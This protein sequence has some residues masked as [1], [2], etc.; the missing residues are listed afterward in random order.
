MATDTQNL[1][2]A[3]RELVAVGASVGAGCHPC[4]AHHLKAGAQAG[5]DGGQLLAAATSAEGVASEATVLVADHA[6][7]QLGVSTAATLTPLADAL[8]ALGAAL[9][10]NDAAAIDLQLRAALDFGASRSQLQQAIETAKTVQEHAGRIHIRKAERLLDSITTT[11]TATETTSD[12]CGCGSADKTEPQQ[13]AAQASDADDDPDAGVGFK[14]PMA[15][16]LGTAQ[17]AEGFAPVTMIGH[18][19]QMFG[20]LFGE[21]GKPAKTAEPPATTAAKGC[22]GAKGA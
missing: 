4:L 13:P 21:T 22:S 2:P 17:D 8:T 18:C 9:G 7:E 16:C 19:R 6:R 12:G 20:G 14:L 15:E 3:Q 11:S 10:A 1:N 5:L